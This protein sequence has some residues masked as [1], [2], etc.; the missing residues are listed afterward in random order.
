[1]ASPTKPPFD[2]PR[3]LPMSWAFLWRDLLNEVSYKFSFFLQLLGIFPVVVMFFFLSRLVGSTISGPLAP[4]G[5]HY[6]PFVLIGIAVQNY[7]ALSL[8]SFSS[9]LRESQLSGTLEVVMASPVRPSAFLAGSAA[10]SFLFNALRI[11]I[12]LAIGAVLF[13][14]H[15]NWLRL[16]AAIGVI[17]LT[18]AAFSSLGIFSAAF[19][20][21]FKRGDP[22]N[23]GFNVISW[24]LGGV[25][26]PV[27]ILPHWLQKVAWFI[28]MTHSLEALRTILLTRG[29]FFHLRRTSVGPG[30]LERARPSLQSHLLSVRL[31]SGQK[32]GEPSGTTEIRTHSRYCLIS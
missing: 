8:S 24:L 10:Y 16:P 30:S 32:A 11:F 21:I 29:G 28:P 13:G 6:F 26:Y 7:L 15:F 23:W 25:Y 14:V 19:I 12:Y 22:V 17:G 20:M 18:I 1:M 27:D 9:R 4:Y 3:T 2:D 31:E 5:G